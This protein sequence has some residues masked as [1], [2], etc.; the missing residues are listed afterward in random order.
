MEMQPYL[1][2]YG[3]TIS[4]FS[5]SASL[6]QLCKLNPQVKL[7]AKGMGSL[8]FRILPHQTI[9]KTL[10]MNASTP[11]KEYLNPWAAF[12]FVGILQGGVYG[13]A[14]I[15][16]AKQL[17]FPKSISYK[18]MFRGVA[19]A[20]SRDVL[21]QGIPFML[22]QEV[23]QTIFDPIWKTEHESASSK[24]K[25]WISIIGT[26]IFATYVS[27]GA[28]NCQIIMQP[29]QNLSYA[30]AVQHAWR[31]NGV[32]LLYKGAEARVGLLIIVNIL[33]ELLLK[34]AWSE[35]VPTNNKNFE[36]ISN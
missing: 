30:E 14:N 34:P 21:S 22:S 24:I 4:L 10:Q 20:G 23:K 3:F 5:P 25:T 8:A 26:S 28:H 17:Q 11:V 19:F 2:G 12:G 18:G 7:S 15:F 32:S 9:L 16:F 13:Q 27:Q 36:G 29:N 1:L 31:Y 33:N 35:L 6:Y